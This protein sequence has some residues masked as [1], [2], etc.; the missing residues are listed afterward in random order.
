MMRGRMETIALTALTGVVVVSASGSG[1]STTNPTE[2]VPGVSTQVVVPRDLQSVRLTVTA[3]GRSVFDSAYDVGANGTVTL[4]STLGVVSGEAPQTVVTITVRG[5]DV[6]CDMSCDCSQ[7]CVTTGDVAVGADGGA[8]ILRR[9]TQTFVDQRTLFV[10]MPLSYSCWNTDCGDSTMGCKGN[11][12]TDA[13]MV[14]SALVDYDPSILDGT[15][16]CFSPALCF[17]DQVDAGKTLA[18]APS[19]IDAD[20]CIY[21]LPAIP[22]LPATAGQINVRAYFQ[23][24]NWVKDATG[25]YQPAFENGGEQ[26][27][28]NQDAVEGFTIVGPPASV[29]ADGGTVATNSTF[30]QLAPGLCTLVKQAATPPKDPSAGGT[31]SGYITISNLRAASLCPPKTPLLPICAG[32]R[33]NGPALPGGATTTDGTCNVPVPLAPTQSALYLLMDHSPAMHGAYGPMG[34]A[35]ALALSLTDPVFK[36][37]YAAFKF[38]PENPA[39]CTSDT[40]SFTTPDVPFDVAGAVQPKIASL[41][42]VPVASP[43]GGALPPLDLQAA[44]RLDAGSY[45]QVIS[46]LK[47]KEL[48]NIAAAMFFVNRAPDLTNDCNPVLGQ[49]STVKAALESEIRAAFS[50][51]PSLQ[52]YFVVLDDDAHDTA[53]ANGALTF[54]QQL[55]ADLPGAVVTLDATQAMTSQQAAQTAAANFAKLVTEL[56]TC[57]YDYALPSGGDAGVDLSQVGVSFTLPGQASSTVVPRA[58]ACSAASQGAVD[59]WNIDNGRLRI[60]GASC[61]T[62]RNGILAEAAVAAQ[63]NVPAQDIPVNASILCSGMGPVNNAAPDASTAVLDSGATNSVGGGATGNP[64]GD[65]GTPDNTQDATVRTDGGSTGSDFDGSTGVISFTDASTDI[66][67]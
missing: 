1:C 60:C 45:A 19:L 16:V 8:R 52:T 61:T 66:P 49:Q 10:P 65:A 67:D 48:P 46:F 41:L 64:N 21:E 2:L 35:T 5:Y 4:P 24:F 14:Q 29:T 55:Q 43:D 20:K 36:R 59:G 12:C 50:G 3:N 53:T 34:S 17:G 13:T 37:T 40:T 62:L 18:L 57:L 28:L 6:T 7:S 25:A 58:P 22:G 63:M 26:E 31:S 42:E 56:G 11:T 33:T 30:F 44:M 32:E 39:E 23:D 51:A 47:G 9:S 38:L 15:D 27:I 54:F